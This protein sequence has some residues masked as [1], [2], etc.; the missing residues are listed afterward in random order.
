MNAA[1]IPALYSAAMAIDGVFAVFIGKYYDKKGMNSLIMIPVLSI[2][3]VIFGF[4]TNA[5]FAV[6]SIILWGCVMS[7]HETIMKAAVADITNVS[8]RGMA[9]GL[10]NTVY[11]MAM[12]LGSTAMGFLYKYSIHYII[13]F[14]ITAEL[15]ALISFI[16]LKNILARNNKAL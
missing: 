12:L 7:I 16:F 11:G 9:Y 2:P 10:F 13:I 8:N 5:V 3:I 4:S 15:L 14:V 1:W 6:V